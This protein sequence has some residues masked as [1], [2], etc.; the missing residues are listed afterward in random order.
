MQNRKE[1]ANFFVG[2]LIHERLTHIK[3]IITESAKDVKYPEI[4]R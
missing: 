4:I 3:Y 2:F 1:L